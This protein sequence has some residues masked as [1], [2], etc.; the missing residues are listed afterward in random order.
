ME[1]GGIGESPRGGLHDVAATTANW[2]RR[3][4]G[5]PLWL[6]AALLLVVL[7]ALIPVGRFDAS[8]SSDE[9]AA[10]LQAQRLEAGQSYLRP[11]E[12]QVIDPEG[13]AFFVTLSE[14]GPREFATYAKHPAY[15]WMLAAIGKV[16]GV[17]G[18]TVLSTLAVVLAAVAGAFVARAW[19]PALARLSLWVLGI[20]SPLLFESQVVLAHSIG[21]ALAGFAALSVI[22]AIQRRSPARLA[23]AAALIATACLF[24][25]EA[26]LFALAVGSALG[27]IA[28]RKRRVDL[29]LG[30]AGIVIAAG[31]ATFA[32][33]FWVGRVLGQ[34]TVPLNTVGENF[35]FGRLGSIAGT[36]ILPGA[37]WPPLVYYALLVLLV[38]LV[39]TAVAVRRHP[40]L[41]GLFRAG[42]VV[43][44][45]A[46]VLPL[47]ATPDT[48][49]SLLITC[50]ILTAGWSLL[51]RD[52]LEGADRR[53]AAMTCIF[54]TVAVLAT[55][56]SE[57]GSAEW[58]A[59][60][61]ALMLPVALP[62]ALM[63]LKRTGASL[64]RP[65]RRLG[66]VALI[67]A[68]MS[69]ATLSITSLRHYRTVSGEWLTQVS[70]ALAVTE[71][72][73]LGDGDGRPIVVTTWPGL[74]RMAWPLEPMPRGL[75]VPPGSL[76]HYAEAM[77]SE[78]IKEFV[79]AST[80]P[81]LDLGQ[82]SGLYAPIRS[83]PE[84]R[85][86]PGP[87]LIM[88]MV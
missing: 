59:R 11:N 10:I 34:A 39:A 62:L 47:T 83:F 22:V 38:A 82:L 27:Y 66:S 19:D 26:M 44:I 67:V 85:A 49:G 9:G 25:T 74:G 53:F 56:Y 30:S 81:E 52:D 63:S 42:C 51:A 43:V 45:V 60:F 72:P 75:S 1:A 14:G 55:Q 78:G 57:G 28:V 87:V 36:F 64:S 46:A 3:C 13:K 68:S 69:M 17:F 23:G 4:W 21:A 37:T 24:R 32:D 16:A 77:R 8:F 84:G 20:G 88:R 86:S 12:L 6:H 71:V 50:P 61:L 41:F 70:H 65:D 33:R 35:L 48:I 80:E 7:V 54:Y 79:L 15:A 31:V 2:F 76:R 73:D 5:A 18:M 40:R 58:G 29:A